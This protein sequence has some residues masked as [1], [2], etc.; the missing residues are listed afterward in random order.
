MQDKVELL[1]K[2]IEKVYSKSPWYGNSVKSVLK[3][4][5]SKTAFTRAAKYPY[6]CR[7][8]CSYYRMA[9]ICYE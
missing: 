7:T 8:C 4:I 3:D 2:K 9:G 5:D 1:T 6:N